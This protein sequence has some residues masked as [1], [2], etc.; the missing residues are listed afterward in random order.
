M[1]FRSVSNVY[2]YMIYG[3]IDEEIE[4]AQ[5]GRV[6][7]IGLVFIPSVIQL[8]SSVIL[9]ALARWHCCY[10]MGTW[11]VGVVFLFLTLFGLAAYY[12]EHPIGQ[13]LISLNINDPNPKNTTK[14]PGQVV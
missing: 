12:M 6:Q 9:I 3:G 14:T 2:L 1:L 11:M 13:I 10:G 5:A 7:G 8:T 4:V